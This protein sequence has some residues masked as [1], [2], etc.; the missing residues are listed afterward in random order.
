MITVRFDDFGSYFLL[1]L[2]LTLGS[3]IL[4]LCG[5]V[6]DFELDAVPTARGGFAP[7]GHDLPRPPSARRIQQETQIAAR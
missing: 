3:T 7:I 1:F 4:D 6:F 2:V 5:E